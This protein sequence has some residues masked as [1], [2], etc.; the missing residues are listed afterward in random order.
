MQIELLMSLS[1]LGYMA[2]VAYT[3]YLRL[4]GT[5][6]PGKTTF[7]GKLLW[8]HGEVWIYGMISTAFLTLAI[9]FSNFISKALNI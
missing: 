1:I 6:A 3:V 5:K 7:L 9:L 2:F 8:Y 4:I